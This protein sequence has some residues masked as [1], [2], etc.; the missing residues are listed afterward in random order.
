MLMERAR[1]MST[2]RRRGGGHSRKEPTVPNDRSD[3]T[4]LSDDSLAFQG[5]PADLASRPVHV[6]FVIDASG[7][8]APK[9]ADVRGGFNAYVAQLREDTASTYRLTAVT[10]DTHVAT[11]FTDVTLDQVPALDETNYRPGGNTALYDA[12]GVSLDELTGALRREDKPYGEE[13]ALVIVMTDGEEN[14]SR[15]FT[16]EQVVSAITAR[17]AAGTWTFVYLGAD[18]DAWAAAAG[19]GFVAGNVAAY[20][21]SDTLD[22]YRK[23]ARSTARYSDSAMPNVRNFG[24]GLNQPDAKDAA[25]SNPVAPANLASPA[26]KAN[27]KSKSKAKR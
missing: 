26:P 21:K 13:R 6:L 19:L 15:R 7:S 4:D 24:T 8:M 17:E 14:S 1:S 18:Q 2:A 9:A 25:P 20:A 22:V 12:L 27:A 10:F 11:L 3:Q 5:L 16:K 23:L